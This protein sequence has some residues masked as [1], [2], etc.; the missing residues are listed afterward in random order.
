MIRPFRL[1]VDFDDSEDFKAFKKEK[2]VIV[3]ATHTPEN[4]EYL[5]APGGIIGF[6]LNW[7]QLACTS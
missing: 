7:K 1:S 5:Q 2:K 4:V 3:A 6:N